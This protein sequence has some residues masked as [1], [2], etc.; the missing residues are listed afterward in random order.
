M[1][2]N[3][4]AVVELHQ[5]VIDQRGV[6]KMEPVDKIC[7]GPGEDLVLKHGGYHIMIMNTK[8]QP[9]TT[10]KLVLTFDNGDKMTVELP[11]KAKGE[12]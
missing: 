7:A 10:I 4:D 8:L 5:T 1:P 11:V 6:A 2:D 9:G 3:P 12:S